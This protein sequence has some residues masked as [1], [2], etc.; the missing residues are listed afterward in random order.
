MFNCGCL[1]LGVVQF[2]QDKLRVSFCLMTL[3][4]PGRWSSQPSSINLWVRGMKLFLRRPCTSR[5]SVW[6]FVDF[7][8]NFDYVYYLHDYFANWSLYFLNT[9]FYLLFCI[10]ILREF[11]IYNWT[12]WL[13]L[14][15]LIGKGNSA[16]SVVLTEMI[17]VCLQIHTCLLFWATNEFWEH[18]SGTKCL[19]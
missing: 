5:V 10:T 1:S 9:K 7:E 18:I 11:S 19:E 8:G 2:D 3:L 12:S 4:Y 14:C 17:D 6:S 13:D 15:I 16:F